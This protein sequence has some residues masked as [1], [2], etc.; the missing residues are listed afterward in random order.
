MPDYGIKSEALGTAMYKTKSGL[1]ADAKKA[2]KLVDLGLF[3]IPNTF[4]PID[5]RSQSQ[6]D[7]Q[8]APTQ[9]LDAMQNFFKEL[10]KALDKAIEVNRS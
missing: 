1:D 4:G 2:G 6:K 8:Q 3:S 9:Y 10:S 7:A 5:L